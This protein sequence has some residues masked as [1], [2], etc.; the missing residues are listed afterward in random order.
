MTDLVCKHASTPVDSAQAAIKKVATNTNNL[1]FTDF[2]AMKLNVKYISI[3]NKL[4]IHI[5]YILIS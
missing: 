1:F 3:Y 5:I 2:Y 4:K